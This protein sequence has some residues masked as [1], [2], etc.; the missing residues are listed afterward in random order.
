M[1]DNLNRTH[2]DIVATG[3]PLWDEIY[4]VR[5]PQSA[6]Y[7]QAQLKHYGRITTGDARLDEMYM[8]ERT[9]V[10]LTIN[11]IVEHY[12]TGTFVEFV[13]N[14]DVRT[15]YDR[16]YAYLQ[17][18]SI[19]LR[20]T[21]TTVD[22]EV[23]GDLLLLDRFAGELHRQSL[24]FNGAMSSPKYGAFGEALRMLSPFSRTKDIDAPADIEH[25]T[26]FATAFTE[27]IAAKNRSNSAGSANTH[28]ASTR[29]S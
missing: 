11:D 21:L 14:H 26:D 3:E 22:D 24:I 17:A 20:N 2:D 16:V 8:R 1:S 15:I 23:I 5:I 19:N 13:V 6:V 10:Y 12:R 4:R 25:H 29:W 28:E 7:S 18:W 27:A 9:E